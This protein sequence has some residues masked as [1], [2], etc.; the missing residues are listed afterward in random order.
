MAVNV[1]KIIVA[2][3]GIGL[4]ALLIVS[5]ETFLQVVG[6]IIILVL[7][8]LLLFNPDLFFK[9]LAAIVG[10]GL[11]ITLIMAP[12]LGLLFMLFLACFFVKHGRPF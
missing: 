4:L 2:L 8:A 12:G 5:P 10:I 6:S 7:F 3:A 1:L 11:L 9:I